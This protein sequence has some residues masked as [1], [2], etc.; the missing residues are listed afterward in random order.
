[1]NFGE[2]MVEYLSTDVAV[3]AAVQLEAAAHPQIDVVEG[4]LN[5]MLGSVVVALDKID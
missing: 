5:R 1:M 2:D 3:A 4:R